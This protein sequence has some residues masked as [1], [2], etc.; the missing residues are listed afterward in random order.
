[1][2]IKLPVF[3]KKV[4]IDCLL[5]KA[6]SYSGY[7]YLTKFNTISKR[8]SDGLPNV[9]SLNSVRVV[10]IDRSWLKLKACCSSANATA[11]GPKAPRTSMT[12]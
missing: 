3:L 8:V 4:A 5:L 9:A 2:D 7:S 10:D 11:P 6:G 1:M 12:A